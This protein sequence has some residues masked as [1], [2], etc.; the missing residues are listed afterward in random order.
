M[1]T[2]QL[3]ENL[4]PSRLPEHEMVKTR[5]VNTYA[6]IH[7]VEES[8]AESIFEKECLYW[9]KLVSADEKL[10]SCQKL[11]LFSA[12]MELAVNGISLQPG[13]KSECYLES[14]GVKAGKDEKGNDKYVN[15]CLI[16][17]TAY[18]E[19]NMRIKSGQIIR[20]KNPI[21]IY[22]G[23]YFQPTT[24]ARGELY[25]EYRPAIPRTSNLIIGCWVCIELPG[26]SL[27]FKWLLIDDIKRLEKKSIPRYANAKANALYNSENGGIDPGFL[28][29][30][31]IKHA[32][33]AYTKL[34]V[35]DNVKMED[36]PEH[37]DQEHEPEQFGEPMAN[38]TETVTF[39]IN[40]NES[41]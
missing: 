21:V 15:V 1:S 3:I 28:E 36:E 17:I 5:W 12:F 11:S 31:T 29:A 30:K 22:Q 18:G 41:F 34:R 13:S 6:K 4:D 8:T 40:A 2:P 33:R 25:I 16:A 32:M 20:M 27:D 7:R 23:D 35:N 14:R 39:Q 24:T 19:L 26:G 10:K 38:N 9:R 37:E